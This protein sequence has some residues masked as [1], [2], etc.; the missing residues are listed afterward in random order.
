MC[1]FLSIFVDLILFRQRVLYRFSTSN[2]NR[3]VLFKSNNNVV[4]YRFST[5]N[6]NAALA[7]PSSAVVV[8][9]RF[10]TS[11]HNEKGRRERTK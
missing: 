1:N 7:L 2:H 5:S 4:L 10:S 6:H 3:D 9:Y 11:N 8:L